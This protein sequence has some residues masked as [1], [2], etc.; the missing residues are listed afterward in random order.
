MQR[1]RIINFSDCKN[2]KVWLLFL[3]VPISFWLVG[4]PWG[5]PDSQRLTLLIPYS[6]QQE[7]WLK[8][9][10][11]D[12]SQAITGKNSV[13]IPRDFSSQFLL[14]KS[15]K[16]RAIRRFLL[17]SEHPDEMLILAALGSMRPQHLQFDPHYYSYGMPYFAGVG[18]SIVIGKLLKQMVLSNTSVFYLNNPA[19]F[20][21]MYVA[22]RI[23]NFI[24]LLLIGLGGVYFYRLI[25]LNMVRSCLG[26]GILLSLP[27]VIIWSCLLKAHIFAS[28]LVLW[29][30]IL[31]YRAF[32]THRVKLAY[33]AGAVIATGTAFQYT[34]SLFLLF[35]IVTLAFII[36]SSHVDYLKHA[37][38]MI[39]LSAA[40]FIILNPYLIM[41]FKTSISDMTHTSSL[42]RKMLP[43]PGIFT[44]SPLMVLA[45]IGIGGATLLLS[46]LITSIL[47]PSLWNKFTL[48]N[49]VLPLAIIYIFISSFVAADG[50]SH[51]EN[52]PFFLLIEPT[53]ILLS[54][55]LLQK[56]LLQPAKAGKH[57]LVVTTACVLLTLGNG[58]YIGDMHRKASLQDRPFLEASRW[59]NTNI[60]VNTNIYL[61]S[62]PAPFS[63]PIFNIIGNNVYVR[64][65]EQTNSEKGIIISRHKLEKGNFT[66][67]KEFSSKR[68]YFRISFAEQHYYIYKTLKK[69]TTEAQSHR[70]KNTRKN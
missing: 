37:V 53:I 52:A 28:A 38:S 27:A 69:S 47:K 25:G 34:A 61:L 22:G 9:V 50:W 40:I 70:E 29:G 16:V 24:A 54:W 41:N 65:I 42:H 8:L 39:L 32:K 62:Q 20:G 56:K 45:G 3:L 68:K 18:T 1:G 21:K 63:S 64:N 57:N 5:I 7:E 15:G 60:P 55:G 19:E 66:L 67:W 43:F 35:P 31:S 30:V 10:G 46:A 58:F 4:I 11:E 48:C 2:S 36:R 13:I 51:P 23:F 6:N 49:I 12:T 33:L 59:I 26:A 44:L 14:D 17:F